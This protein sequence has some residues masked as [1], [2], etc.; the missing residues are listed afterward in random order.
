MDL[1]FIGQGL[2]ST[3]DSTT[4]NMIIESLIDEKFN[5]RYK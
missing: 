4:G 5:F 3:S 2:D 1:V